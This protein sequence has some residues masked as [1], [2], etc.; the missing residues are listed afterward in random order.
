MV[1]F[2]T[3]DRVVDK[4]TPTSLRIIC[5]GLPRTATSSMQA[6]VEKLGFGPCLHMAN[7]LPHV[8]RGQLMLTAVRE[9]D[10]AKRQKLIRQLID[11]H[12][13]IADLPIVFF[14][15]DLMDMYPEAKVVLNQ[16]HDANVWSVSTHDSFDFFFSWR[17]W[18][19]GMLFKTDRIW[20]ALNMEVIETAKGKYGSHPFDPESHDI[21]TRIVHE[22]A[23]KRNAEVLDFT[24]EQG[25]EPL[26][27]FLGK[28]V[29]AEPFPRVNEKKTF[30][31]IKA[32]FIAKGLLGWAAL[33]GGIWASW[34]YGPS[35]LGYARS[36]LSSM[37]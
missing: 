13:S 4:G 3:D 9:R 6:A 27:K 5:A 34:R 36:W 12:A 25:W 24:P 20:Y 37:R 2:P 30:Q 35:A 11:G 32:I 28:E 21:H 26:C 33:G 15:P 18:L 29:P 19:T 22:E 17:F 7:I 16:R 8:E 31:I 1:R 23:A 10:T 14:L